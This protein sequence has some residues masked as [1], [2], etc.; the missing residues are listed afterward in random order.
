MHVHDIK[1][2]PT[3]S[4]LILD[5]PLETLI[6]PPHSPPAERLLH[7]IPLSPEPALKRNAGTDKREKL[8]PQFSRPPTCN[9]D[10]L[11]L[12]WQRYGIQAVRVGNKG[13]GNLVATLRKGN[14]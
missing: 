7:T 14:E 11:D 4:K 8:L 6:M 5:V 1:I 10:R 2:F 3:V 12:S 9:R 13:C